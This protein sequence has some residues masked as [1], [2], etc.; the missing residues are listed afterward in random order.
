MNYKYNNPCDVII[1]LR[2]VFQRLNLRFISSN[3]CGPHGYD[4][5][6]S[7]CKGV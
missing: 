3:Y 1:D 7:K 2:K 5:I 6:K 4:R